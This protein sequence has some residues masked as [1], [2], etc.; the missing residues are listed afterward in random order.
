MKYTICGV[1]LTLIIAACTQNKA[2]VDSETKDVRA[3]SVNAFV[4]TTDTVKKE[5][6]LPGEL[7]PFEDAQ[8]RAKVPGY[9]RKMYV[10]IGSKISKGQILALVEA[11]ELNTRITELNEKARAAHARYL[12]SKDYYDRIHTA[13]QTAGVIAAGELQRVKNQMMSDSLEYRAEQSS[14]A[15]AKQVGNYLAIVAPYSGIITKRN[16]V[17]GSFVGDPNGKPLFELSDNRVLRLQVAVP[18]AYVDAVLL[19]NVAELTTLSLPDK[20]FM[21]KLVRQSGSID[22]DSRSEIW[23]FEVPNPNNELKPGSYADVKLHFLRQRPGMVVPASSVVTTL[24][25]KFVIGVFNGQTQWIDVRTG[26][27]MGDKIEI[28]GNITPGDT[29][30]QKGT[31]ELKAATRVIPS[32]VR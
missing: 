2:N 23:E 17:T 28:F 25:R 32:I 12:S 18:E 11:P 29:L 9:I 3:D 24:E 5:L 14:A 16:V 1:V 4:L 21:A 26:F 22:Q 13:S 30:V 27:N 20:I 31:E 19:N 7:I 15:S 10:D 8:I 6:T